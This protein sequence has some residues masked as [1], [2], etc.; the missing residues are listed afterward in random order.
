MRTERVFTNFTCN[1][2]CVF[3]NSRSGLDER[4]FIHPKAV[5]QRI[6]DALSNGARTLVLT[7]GEPTLRRDIAEL[8][9]EARACG[10][11]RVELETNATLVD[12]AAAG[13]LREAG[14]T[15]ARVNVSGLIPIGDAVTRDP[16]GA[17][18]TIGGI[19]ALRAE[20]LPVQLDAAIVRST[21]PGLPELPSVLREA[22]GSLGELQGL[23]LR[24]PVEGPDPAE[25]VSYETAAAAIAALE[26]RARRLELQLHLAPDSGPMPC[27]FRHQ[28]RVAHLFSL[29]PGST[30][31]PNHVQ[32]EACAECQLADR[33]SGLPRAYL[34]RHPAP[35][36]QPIQEDRL[37]RRLSLVGTTQ[38]QVRREFVTET[39]RETPDGVEIEK[40]IRVNFHC[41]QSCRFC[42]V[43]TH[44]P[45]VADE[46][47]RAAIRQAGVEGAFIVLSGGEPTLNPHIVEYV[48]LARSNSSRRITLQ[49]NATRLDESLV[50]RLAE[51]GLDVAFV[52]LHGSTAEIS[53]AIT[54]A[55]GTWDLT[56]RGID[57]LAR[58]SIYVVL[59][60]VI[61]QRNLTDLVPYVRFVAR[62]WPAAFLSLSFVA[63]SSDVVPKEAALIPRYSDALPQISLAVEEARRLGL[64]I[65]GFESMCGLPLCLVPTS[66][67]RYLDF[68]NIPEGYDGGEF[69]KTE[70]CRRCA[71]EQK[72]YG[73]RRGYRDLHGEGEL[74]A[75]SA[76][77][78]LEAVG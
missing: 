75:V 77:A 30:R 76:G 17:R 65:G 64:S 42:F 67:A 13:R 54:E 46:E 74:R 43:S 27:M 69:V 20:G 45:S 2:G 26:D 61:C 35:P 71:L 40:I 55:P 3:C 12:P 8:V 29:T 16:G 48:E 21:L 50:Q 10:A 59:N 68:T 49:T 72:C 37:R 73:L 66:L 39:R 23:Q 31:N 57:H 11:E 78:A 51:G 32:V 14:L 25:L 6:R 62:R 33:C 53:D 44:L 60:F 34:A 18:A 24:V 4:A 36:M 63:P 15:L 38:E 56:V 70:T 47:T 19:R 7:G 5:R 22:L 58:S 52:S 28:A 41:N 1:Q 9:R